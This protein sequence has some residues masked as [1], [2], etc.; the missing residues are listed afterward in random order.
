[1][2]QP[3]PKALTWL[4]QVETLGLASLHRRD[5]MH[6]QTSPDLSWED[7]KGTQLGNSMNKMWP[8]TGQCCGGMKSEAGVARTAGERGQ[9][10]TWKD[11]A[12]EEAS[13]GWRLWPG[14]E[15][16]S[17]ASTGKTPGL[18]AGGRH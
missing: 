9:S 10:R 4:V 15:A 6:A 3:V 18:G 5:Q 14:S 16:E 1:M 17:P 13:A 11:T 2:L 7:Q 12:G 8:G